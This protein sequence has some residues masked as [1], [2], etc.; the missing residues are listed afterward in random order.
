LAVLLSG[1]LILTSCTGGIARGW[2][3]GAVYNGDLFVAS[4]KGR[5]IAVDA[6]N[7]AVLGKPVLLTVPTS[8]GILGCSPSAAPLEI[9]ASPLVINT[10]DPGTVVFVAGVD[11][12]I[13]GFLFKDGALVE[14]NPSWLSEPLGGQI[15]GGIATDNNVVYAATATGTIYALNA[16]DLSIKW[17]H[18]IDS[19]VW[20]TPVV[21]GDTLYIGC[22]NKTVYA[23]NL[24]DG[25][26]KWNKK[27]DGSINAPPLVLDNKVFIGDYSRHFYA[28]DAATGNIVWKFPGDDTA[29]GNPQNWFWAAPVTLNGIIYAPSLDG[30]IYELDAATGTLKDTITLGDSISSSPVLVGNTLVATTAV[31]SYA[32]TKQRGK[33]YIIDITNNNHREVD[34]PP[35]EEVNAP[36]FTSGSNVY[37]HTTKDNLF[38]IDA[39]VKDSQIKLIFNLSSVK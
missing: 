2:A 1:T 25:K 7:N 11:G 33:V 6:S 12:K 35:N 15:Y 39:A 32:P 38:S 19:K 13:H 27:L 4:M 30:N 21:S 14:K 37:F 22:F 36:L 20:S 3:G 5:I 29:A 17:S 28:L 34:F 26:E 18:K 10:T 16:K 24:A 31:V 9:Y 23:L 8:S